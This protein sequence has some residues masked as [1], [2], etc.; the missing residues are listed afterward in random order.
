MEND[1]VGCPEGSDC[2]EVNVGWTTWLAWKMLRGGTGYG[3]LRLP[4]VAT[5]SLNRAMRIRGRAFVQF[6]FAVSSQDIAFARF[7]AIMI[8]NHH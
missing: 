5:Y 1:W 8:D 3:S 2:L 4:S 6:T 7:T